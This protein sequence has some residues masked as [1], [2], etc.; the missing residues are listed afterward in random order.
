MKSNLTLPQFML[1]KSI[2]A[3]PQFV[4]AFFKPAVRLISLG[5]AEFKGEIL[6]A[7]ER[8]KAVVDE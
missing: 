3:R 5:L 7:T 4:D 1:L 2:V 6:H 8:G